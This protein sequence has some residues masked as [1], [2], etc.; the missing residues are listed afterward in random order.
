MPSALE[1]SKSLSI[2]PVREKHAHFRYRLL[3][4]EGL[5][6]L[7]ADLNF[8]TGWADDDH[9][10]FVGQPG[11]PGRFLRFDLRTF[12][13]TLWKEVT[14]PDAA[15]VRALEPILKTVANFSAEFLLGP[16]L[17]KN[18]PAWVFS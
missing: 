11:A 8:V 1:T 9:T 2:P 18:I 6:K 12:R 3:Q 17:G 13:A 16:R 5:E 15:G 10:V 7:G 4:R 14:P